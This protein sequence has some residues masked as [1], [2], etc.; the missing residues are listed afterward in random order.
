MTGNDRELD[1]IRRQLKGAIPPRQDRRLNTDLWPRMLRRME[2]PSVT[3]GLFESLLVA[4]VV[5][6]FVLFP[7]LIPVMLYHL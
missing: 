6:S 3:F 2:E 5:L 4:L 7:E 1:F